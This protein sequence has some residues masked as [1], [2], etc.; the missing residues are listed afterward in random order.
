MFLD[1]VLRLPA[2]VIR[3]KLP[4]MY[5]QFKE[6]ADVDITAEPME[7]GPTCHYVMGGVE[8]D[9][10][11]EAARVPGPV[12]GRRGRRRHARL[13][14]ARRQLAVRPA[15]VRAPGRC[16][17][18]P[19]TSTRWAAYVPRSTRRPSTPRRRRRSRRSSTEGGENP[20]TLHHDLQQSMNDL[21]GIIR[22][23]TEIEQA[24]G[25]LQ[26]L[27]AA[28]AARDR[29]GAPAVQ[30]GLAPRARPAT[31]CCWSPSASPGRRWSA[32][33]SRG[34]HTRD[35]FPA[36]NPEW[37]KVNLICCRSTGRGDAGRVIHQPLPAMR[38][39]LLELFDGSS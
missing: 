5:H 39:D 2:E 8:V 14:P 35:D 29:R 3:K 9:P 31:T 25:R 20:Y 34:G 12:R 4:S 36:M 28:R 24:L 19:T 22:T 16:T 6:L 15:G 17:A 27:K 37:R 32:Q 30:P 1:V 26:D 21:V 23:A 33:E 18:R 13:Q 38:A 10:D 11:T 7:V